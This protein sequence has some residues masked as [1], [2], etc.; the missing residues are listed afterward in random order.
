[1]AG[2][3]VTA[4]S[5]NGTPTIFYVHHG[6]TEWNRARRYQGRH[7]SALTPEGW[8]QAAR[9][10][11]LLAPEVGTMRDVTLVS[12]PLGRAVTTAGII[13]AALGLAVIRDDRLAELSLGSWEGLT[14]GEIAARDPQALSAG[15]GW[16]WCYRAPGGES[17]ESA[18][19]RLTAWLAAVRCPTIAVGHGLAGRLLRGLYAGLDRTQMLQLPV[20][21]DG[22]FKLEAG[23]TTFLDVAEHGDS[24]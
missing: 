20:R 12:S 2:G 13:A 3:S 19:A 9:V 7:D 10:A 18:A 21:R 15:A 11:A 1:M 14:Q 24:P 8:Q 6:E 17:F 16:N 22:V 23:R 4:A 5:H